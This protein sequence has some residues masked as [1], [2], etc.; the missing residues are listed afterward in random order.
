MDANTTSTDLVITDAEIEDTEGGSEVAK[1]LA[2]GAV[3][4]AV[5]VGVVIVYRRVIQPRVLA[6]RN[7]NN[8]NME[9][10]DAI[11]VETPETEKV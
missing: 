5:A 9:V 11:I 8:E 1:T 4:T 7:R 3:T 6:F 10:V 2:V